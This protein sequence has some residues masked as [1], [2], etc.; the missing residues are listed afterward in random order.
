MAAEKRP[1]ENTKHITGEMLIAHPS[2]AS[3]Q[4]GH[5]TPSSDMEEGL[6]VSGGARGGTTPLMPDKANLE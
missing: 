5:P 4:P 6:R 1:N 2:P 3:S